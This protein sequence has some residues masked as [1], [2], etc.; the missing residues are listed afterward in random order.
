MLF[1]WHFF[2]LLHLKDLEEAKISADVVVFISFSLT[3]QY[4]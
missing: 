4:K 1:F 3:E 2:L